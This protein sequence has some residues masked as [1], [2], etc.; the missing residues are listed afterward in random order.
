MMDLE[1]L[2]LFDIVLAL[3][4][5]HHLNDA[6]AVDV[7]EL[8]AK[9][10]KPGGRLVTIDPC[11]DPLQNPIARLLIRGDRGQNVRD[12]AGYEALASVFFKSPL[13]KVRHTSWIP[14]THCIMEC[15][16]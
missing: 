15:Q 16:K 6:V 3:G 4:L 11:F 9:A 5:L 7:M 12:R 1:S 2:P 14:Y 8:A 10:L 13:V